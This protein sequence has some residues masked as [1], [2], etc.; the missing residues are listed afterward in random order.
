MLKGRLKAQ[1]HCNITGE[2]LT[3]KSEVPGPSHIGLE[4]CAATL[5]NS[6]DIPYEVK[7][8]ITG[9]P[10]SGMPRYPTKKNKSLCP[11][12]HLSVTKDSFLTDTNWKHQY[13]VTS[14]CGI[15]TQWTTTLQYK[16]I[17]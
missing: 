12:K 4:D 2:V 5:E 7:H 15:G 8:K 17:N 6:L 14:E 10:S 1:G 3:S 11:L 16:G 13:S 9:M